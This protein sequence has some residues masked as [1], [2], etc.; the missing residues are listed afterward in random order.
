ML[1]RQLGAGGVKRSI[2]DVEGA[3]GW[4]MTVGGVA[5]KK[6]RVEEGVGRRT[7]EVKEPWVSVTEDDDDV[8][9]Q[10]DFEDAATLDAELGAN[11]GALH[12]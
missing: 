1:K 12:E 5:R 9:R 6:I 3:G 10:A 4:M 2:E 8:I 7:L 11:W